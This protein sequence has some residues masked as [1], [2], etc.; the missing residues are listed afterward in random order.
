MPWMI[1]FAQSM[2]DWLCPTCEIGAG[3]DDVDGDVGEDSW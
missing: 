1:G 2:D 3:D